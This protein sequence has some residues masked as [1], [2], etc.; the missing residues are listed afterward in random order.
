MVDHE[1]ARVQADEPKRKKRK[2]QEQ[3]DRETDNIPKNS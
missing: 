3:V 1:I 2:L